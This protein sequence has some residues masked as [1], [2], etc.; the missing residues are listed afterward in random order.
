MTRRYRI[1]R[2][3]LEQKGLNQ[4]HITSPRGNTYTTT[5]RMAEITMEALRQQAL[6][7]EAE[8]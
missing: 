2:W 6:E 4:W 7:T 1:R 3:T 8:S 5:T